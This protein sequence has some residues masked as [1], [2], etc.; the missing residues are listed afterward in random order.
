MDYNSLK[1]LHLLNKFTKEVD[2]EIILKKSNLPYDDFVEI[3][4]N[5]NKSDYIRFVG[6]GF[7]ET[8]N[9]GKTFFPNSLIKWIFNNIL[10]II[11]III[12]IIA[13]FN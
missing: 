11:A 6:N 2:S 4:N 3:M 1:I 7:V 13:L 10:A 8:T 5:L 9:K 12:S